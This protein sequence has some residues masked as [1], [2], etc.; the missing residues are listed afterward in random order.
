MPRQYVTYW[1]V[2][3]G[4]WREGDKPADS[5]PRTYLRVLR[6]KTNL[7]WDKLAHDLSVDSGCKV[8]G[9]NARRWAK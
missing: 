2:M 6:L 8:S 5:D 3:D 4:L 1:D 9:T 7:S